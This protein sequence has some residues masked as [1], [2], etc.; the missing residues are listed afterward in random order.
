MATSTAGGSI[1]VFAMCEL[2]APAC[3]EDFPLRVVSSRRFLCTGVL[4]KRA[5]HRF[6]KKH[7][8]LDVCPVLT[9]Q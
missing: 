8:G 2:Y 9:E 3:R 1:C 6:L 4:S 7:P 5:S